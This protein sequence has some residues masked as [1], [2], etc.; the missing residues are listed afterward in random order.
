MSGT[1][2]SRQ[3]WD[4]PS[5]SSAPAQGNP[6]GYP[7]VQGRCP[8]CGSE[9]LFLGS[10]GYVTCGLIGGRTGG[11]C[12]DPTAASQALEALS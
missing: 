8:A 6:A 7:K 9:T 12:P 5:T 11:G 2:P 3:W 1:N 10:G 4:H